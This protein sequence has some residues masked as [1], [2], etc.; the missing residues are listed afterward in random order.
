MELLQ[1]L[2][3]LCSADGI[4]GMEQGALSTAKQALE[5]A[6]TFETLPLGSLICWVKAAQEGKPHL[7]LTAHMDTIGL[8]V[9]YIRDDGFLAVGNCGGIDRSMVLASQVVV[10]TKAGDIP[11]VVCS[12]PPHLNPDTEKLPKIEDIFIDIGMSKEQAESHVALGDRIS[13]AWESA[14]MLNGRFCSKTLDDRAGCA[15]VIMAAQELAKQEL[16]CGLSVALTTLEEVGGQGAKTAAAHLSPTHAIA[17]DVSFAATPDAPRHKCGELGK[18]P[19]IGISPILDN[20]MAAQ[21]KDAAKH[22]D[23]PVQFEVMGGN[24]GTD[25]DSV[26]VSGAGVRCALL[27]IPLRYMHTPIELVQVSD[28]EDT[29]K[30]IVQYVKEQ[31]GGV[32]R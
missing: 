32:A 18:G 29:A 3:T 28:V 17:V 24:T 23:M 8:V 11:G 26:A 2:K 5:G 30:L 21:M 13:F 7:M 15:S 16:D 19:M 4:A 9:T 31:F 14:E 6:G 20:D 10:H 22:I 27:S 1:M 12:I 25:A